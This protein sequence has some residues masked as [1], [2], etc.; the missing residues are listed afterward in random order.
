MDNKK[1]IIIPEGTKVIPD[2]FLLNNK[3]VEEIIMPDSVIEIGRSAFKGCTNLKKIKLSKNL[4]LAGAFCFANCTNLESI[5]LPKS[6]HY[7]CYGMFSECKRLKHI[8]SLDSINFIEDY[9]LYN[10]NSLEDFNIPKKCSSL[11]IKSLYGLKKV[12]TLHIPNTLTDIEYGALG[13]M[14]NLKSFTCS[15]DH[16]VFL[17]DEGDT[18]FNKK[19]KTLV[20]YAPNANKEN[21]LVAYVEGKPIYLGINQETGEEQY[22][23][24]YIHTYNIADYAF[25]GA[26]KL[27]RMEIIAF[28]ER[29]GPNT[30]RN[31][32]NLKEL[33]FICD[34]KY[35]ENC[36]FVCIKHPKQKIQSSFEKIT[37]GNGI[38]TIDGNF[39]ELLKNA[40][41]VILP[42]TLEI[43]NEDTFEDAS[44]LKKLVVPRGIKYIAP[45]V[46]NDNTEVNIEGFST[47]KGSNFA[48]FQ[49]LED[50]YSPESNYYEP[51]KILSYNDGRF[52]IKTHGM[53]PIILNSNELKS[54]KIDTSRNNDE[55]FYDMCGILSTKQ[56][57]LPTASSYFDNKKTRELFANLIRD[58]NDGEDI[59][60]NYK[61]QKILKLINEPEHYK[62]LLSRK[63][64]L[65]Y[66]TYN[67]LKTMITNY[68]YSLDKFL[69]Y[70]Q[71]EL[72]EEQIINNL[73][74]YYGY[75]LTKMVA[76][77]ILLDDY[78]RYD[79]FFYNPI[80]F[81]GFNY[82]QLENIIKH[83]SKNLKR[84]II[85]SKVLN[86]DTFYSINCNGFYKL[87]SILGVFEDDPKTS[88]RACTYLCDKVFA[89]KNSKSKLNKHRII[90]DRIHTIF[91]SLNLRDEFDPK[92]AEFFMENYEELYELEEQ[93]S[94]IISRIYNSFDEI[95][96]ATRKDS[97]NQNLKKVTVERCKSFFLI[98]KF[99]NIEIPNKKLIKLLSKYYDDELI[100]Y[101]GYQIYLESRKAPRNIFSPYTVDENGNK[102]YS[103]SKKHDL[104][105][106]YDNNLSFEWL[107][108]QDLTNLILGKKCGCCAHINGNGAGIM[109]ASM[110]SDNCQ[111][112]VIKYKGEIFA[113][114][115]VYVNKKEGYAIFNTIE[116]IYPIKT[117]EFFK[118]T[119]DTIMLGVKAF[120]N[121]YN[122]NNPN[123]QINEISVGTNRNILAD[124][125]KEDVDTIKSSINY[126]NYSYYI[127]DKEY[128]KYSGDSASGQKVLYKQRNIN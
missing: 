50:V 72:L 69:K 38:T 105:G 9:A 33:T 56:N 47:F 7:L 45:Y 125:I 26:K 128:G 52:Y 10:C 17:I 91:D 75:G 98:D 65:K 108:K 96:N 58:I 109:R 106:T 86:K 73:G 115:T 111:N 2:N 118:Q 97:G 104:K 101:K 83:Y 89:E 43:I 12:Y 121:A 122:K 29:Y 67:Q 4:R 41:K 49:T 27:K 36:D 60:F 32:E 23:P 46:F 28:C 78:K 19:T 113:K 95:K 120:V 85:A 80:L 124:Y 93:H 62:N 31:C 110:I 90:G 16:P 8:G 51:T 21:Y 66:A 48:T 5:E 59:A 39:K 63:D 81:T 61:M 37:F 99:E 100:L 123:H 92:F 44:K 87:C 94:G 126:S 114:M 84:T 3:D 71:P 119:L 88:Q 35:A 24:D 102:K 53:E 15:E 20:R 64:I 112:L 1:T 55:L 79:K 11:G 57:Y 74:S 82:D 77:S 30:F 22:Y 70:T 76:Y 68:D 42:S 6:L 14:P 103:K 107:P 34:N 54:D 117:E 127:K 18:L 116:A 25:D 40:K 13:N